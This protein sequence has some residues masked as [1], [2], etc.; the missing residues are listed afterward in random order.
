MCSDPLDTLKD[1]L[2]GLACGLLVYWVLTHGSDPSHTAASSDFLA[3]AVR[4]AAG[5]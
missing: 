5:P 4:G 3:G 1:L 2:F